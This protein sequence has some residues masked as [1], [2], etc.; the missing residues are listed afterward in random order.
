MTQ[1]HCYIAVEGQQD[2]LFLGRLIQTIG[3]PDVRNVEDISSVWKPLIDTRRLTE[4]QGLVSAGRNGL[5]LHQLF[6][7]VCFQN[8]THSIVV[9]KVGGRGKEFRRNLESFDSVLDGGL[10]SLNSVGL[11]PDADDNP[12]AVR[13]G[14]EAAL[15][16]VKLQ[17]PF[18]QSNIFS[19]KPNT[20]IYALPHPTVAGAVEELML[21]CAECVYPELHSGAFSFV[22]S[23]VKSSPS[24]T[25]G[26]LTEINGPRGRAKAAVGCISSYLKPGSTVQVSILKDR[27]VSSNTISLPRV[28]ALVIFLKDLCGLQ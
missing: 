16:A 26:D 9:R 11:V 25:A 2:I 19:G 27:W 13:Q 15:R 20:G 14:C 18:A 8:E 3:V 1:M 21:D 23:I 4:H 12:A 7:G 22:D 24:F 6:S 5:E 10:A 28:A 17:V